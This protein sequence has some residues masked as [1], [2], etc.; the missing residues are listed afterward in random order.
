MAEVLQA[1][2]A[3]VGV[4]IKLNVLEVPAFLEKWRSGDFDLAICG[5][6]FEIDPSI[7]LNRWMTKDTR[8]YGHY[9]NPEFDRLCAEAVV[10]VDQAKR[11]ELY[12]K[13]YHHFVE[14]A[15]VIYCIGENRYSAVRNNIK[16]LIK[17]FA[18]NDYTMLTIK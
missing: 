7:Q 11:K 4:T 17:R 18:I 3:R 10:T 12:Y 1:Q 13:A 8:N 14:D 15:A 5:H 9:S 2:L 6:G 16:G